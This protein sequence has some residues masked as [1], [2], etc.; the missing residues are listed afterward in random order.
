MV[1]VLQEISQPLCDY[2]FVLWCLFSSLSDHVIVG[3]GMMHVQIIRT[4]WAQIIIEWNET[5]L[6]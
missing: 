5:D 3:W 6:A 2:F 4:L 1:I